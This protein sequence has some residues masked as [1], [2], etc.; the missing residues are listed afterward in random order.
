[1]LEAVRGVP[2]V[3]DAGL[4]SQLPLTGQ[5]DQYGI[6][7]RD[8]A[9]VDPERGSDAERYTVSTDYMRAM[10]IRM[11]RGRAFAAREVRDT[12]ARVVIISDALAERMWPGRDALG[13]HISIGGAPPGEQPPYFRVIGV[14][15]ATR[16]E[17]LDDGAIS[18]VYI[19]ERQ[20]RWAENTMVLVARVDGRPEHFVQAIFEAVRSVDPT[21]PVMRIAT[22]E[23][24]VMRSIGQRR[25]GML[26]F[27]TF[28]AMALLLAAAGIYGVLA[29]AVTE[30]TREFGVRAAFGAT[31]AAI[32]RLVLRDGAVLTFAGLAIGGAGALFLARYLSALLYG[33][34]ARDPLSIAMAVA[35]I[36]IVA[37]AACVVP[38][39]RA[40][41]ADPVTALRAD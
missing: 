33:V 26:L 40:T 2:G 29:G 28:G 1:V 14:A 24:V 16:H 23:Q 20:W 27:V 32:T 19:P 41:R 5:M 39:R 31:P 3:T 37:L 22:M 21:Q 36:A 7:D 6:R 15:A 10:R 8:L 17:G 18:Q 30:R 12:G 38:A 11:L 9:N 4:T 34:D 35:A 25:L 13:R